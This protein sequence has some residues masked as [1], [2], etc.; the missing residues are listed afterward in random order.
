MSDFNV[1]P[2]RDRAPARPVTPAP[3]SKSIA[4]RAEDSAAT[5]SRLEVMKKAAKKR[6]I[7][8]YKKLFH[9]NKDVGVMAEP[10]SADIF[11]WDATMLGC[12]STIRPTRQVA[13]LRWGREAALACLCMP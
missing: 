12:A 9:T 10:N 11:H 7:N 2:A 4:A 5:M 1:V 13:L 3:H 6:I 8:E